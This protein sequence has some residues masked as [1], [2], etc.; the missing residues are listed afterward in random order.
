[1]KRLCGVFSRDNRG[2]TAVEFAMVSVPFLGLLFAI[3][4]TAYLF[5]VQ[6]AVDAAATTG[7]RNILTGQT[8]S[9]NLTTASAFAT[10]VICPNLPSFLSCS[11]LIIDVRSASSSSWST[12]N[13]ATDFLNS[14]SN[15]FCIGNPNDIVIVR[16][17]YP[18]PAY[19]SIM[20]LSSSLGQSGKMTA[21][22]SL[23]TSS[24]NMVYPIM[25]VSAFKNE[26]FTAS[27]Y[28]FPTGC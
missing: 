9:S 24:N 7:G 3:F 4:Q 28:S 20:T 22:Q 13:T 25:G 6:Q 1:M 5:L 14:S 23:Q 18:V 21:G 8:M 2:T 15:K 19:L 26:P 12:L 16:I 10:T 11:S 27:T 17:I